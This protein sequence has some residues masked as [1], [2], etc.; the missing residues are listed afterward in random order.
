MTDRQKDRQR[1]WQ[2]SF[3]TV[4]STDNKQTDALSYNTT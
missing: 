3:L 4:P 1:D 2:K